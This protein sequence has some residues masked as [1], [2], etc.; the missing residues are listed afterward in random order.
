MPHQ[1]LLIRRPFQDPAHPCIA[2]FKINNKKL[3]RTRINALIESFQRLLSL[4][5]FSRI[6]V[7]V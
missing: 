7:L 3:K 1:T 5:R 2:L 6:H 4:S